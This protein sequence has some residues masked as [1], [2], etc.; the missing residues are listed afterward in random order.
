MK[1]TDFRRRRRLGVFATMFNAATDV[2]IRHYSARAQS[3]PPG[4]SLLLRESTLIS[5]HML[6]WRRGMRFHTFIRYI[7]SG[8]GRVS[9]ASILPYPVQERK[10]EERPA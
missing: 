4:P 6:H 8:L 7:S 5:A 10:L 3:P 2:V 9:V 1:H